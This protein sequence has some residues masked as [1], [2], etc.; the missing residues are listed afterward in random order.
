MDNASVNDALARE[1]A[2]LLLK[3]YG[4]AFVPTNAQIHCIAH[5][6]N[7]VV[8]QILSNILDID[9]PALADYYELYNKHLP[10]HYDLA[11]DE[12]LNQWEAEGKETGATPV[13]D[14]EGEEDSEGEDADEL[15]KELA[16]M[17]AAGSSLG[18]GGKAAVEKLHLI[19]KKIV[20]SP[21]R[22]ARFRRTAERVY[23]E[24]TS[25]EHVRL[26]SLMVVRDAINRWVLD[27]DETTQLLFL[28]VQEWELLAKIGS[29]L[30]V[31]T[32]VTKEMSRSRTPTLPYVLP[33]YERM[34]K[35]LDAYAR[36]VKISPDIRN[37]AAAG[38]RKLKEYYNLAKASQFTLLA[39][40]LHPSLR[41]KW[42]T[43][44]YG[45]GYKDGYRAL[46]E[47]V[48]ND[49]ASSGEAQGQ[50][51]IPKPSQE[52]SGDD[53]LSEVCAIP[54]ASDGDSVEPDGTSIASTA[55]DE[56]ERY[57]RGEGSAASFHEPLRWWKVWAFH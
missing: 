44:T 15:D 12:D 57:L 48:Y 32:K 4:I 9:D 52:S 24:A 51:A 38:L 35:S 26:R 43:S 31:F 6:V 10:F 30:E 3:R 7:L 45:D 54:E 36:D 2:R 14:S 1:L 22:R 23:P 8:Q 39:T 33:M 47:H 25:S 29:L 5:V 50:S 53:F 16:E 56:V 17:L 40:M 18:N 42:L 27:G 41:L 21:Q 34:F 28:T 13:V 19:V 49:Y 37:A 46:F 55:K 11:D 20:S